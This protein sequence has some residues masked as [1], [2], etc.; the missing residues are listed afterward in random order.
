MNKKQNI[1]V[2]GLPDISFSHAFRLGLASQPLTHL[3][4][5]FP[6]IKKP[7]CLY[8]IL[9]FSY[10]LY[11][12]CHM[13]DSTEYLYTMGLPLNATHALLCFAERTLVQFSMYYYCM[14]L[15]SGTIVVVSV[16]QCV[17][18]DQDSRGVFPTR[19]DAS[20]S[21]PAWVLLAADAFSP[22]RVESK[23]AA[24]ASTTRSRRRDHSAPA[25]TT[26][27]RTCDAP[28]CGR[29]VPCVS[30]SATRPIP[31]KLESG[32]DRSRHLDRV[33]QDCTAVFHSNL[34]EEKAFVAQ[35]HPG[36][37][38]HTGTALWR[39]HHP[40]LPLV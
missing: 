15:S 19:R 1:L 39:E 34:C 38:I 2:S 35:Q 17:D 5:L 33:V 4:Q 9:Q 7:R 22:H 20:G 24:P 36:W 14:F 27:D 13:S 16:E 30:N 40:L 11:I 37:G 32:A 25:R 21:R 3:T 29:V 26:G 18:K 6:S 28:A 31:Q 23:T 8:A 10:I 12:V